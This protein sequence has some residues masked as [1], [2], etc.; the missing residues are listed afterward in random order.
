MQIQSFDK[1]A[2]SAYNAYCK[3]YCKTVFA[4]LDGKPLPT[5]AKLGEVRKNHWI[6]VA[7]QVDA[8]VAALH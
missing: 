2:E 3:S 7:Q 4:T 1:L 5:Y 8:E 6:A